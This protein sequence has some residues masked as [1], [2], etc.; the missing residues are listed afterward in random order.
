MRSLIVAVI[1]ALVSA[2]ATAAELEVAFFNVESD[3]SERRTIGNQIARYYR[4]HQIDL[5]AFAEIWD[6][7]WEREFIDEISKAHDRATR[8]DIE[9]RG[10]LGE[11]GGDNRLLVVYSPAKL[12]VVRSEELSGLAIR[13]SNPSPLMVHFRLRGGPEF[14]LVVARLDRYREEVREQ[15]A[16]GLN[17][18][19]SSQ[20]LPVLAVG[21]FGFGWATKDDGATREPAYDELVA[22]DVFSWVR[23]G[24]VVATECGPS[25][26]VEDFVFVAG[27]ARDWP[28]K[29]RVLSPAPNYCPDSDLTSSHRPLLAQIVYQDANA[30]LPVVAATP[31]T[32]PVGLPT[33]EDQLDP[34][35]REEIL[36]RIAVIEAELDALKALLGV[37]DVLEA[38]R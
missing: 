10:V 14:L 38:A 30:V 28:V 9:F 26:T 7:D 27:Q 1:L 12:E 29:T 32:L 21:T 20:T 4:D 17:R 15:A 13:R 37:E 23:P 8:Q 25:E 18:W 31:S 24:K 36:R 34:A 33:A 35:T 22:G 2:A 3:H 11:T 6:Q 5:W 16:E 19:A